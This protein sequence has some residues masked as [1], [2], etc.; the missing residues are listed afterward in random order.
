MEHSII[1]DINPNDRPI[2]LKLLESHRYWNKNR[3]LF[4][5]L[6]GLAGLASTIAF[7]RSTFNVFDILGLSRGAL[8]QMVYIP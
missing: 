5:I 7:G 4:N 3:L 8:L 1:E 2:A 6:V